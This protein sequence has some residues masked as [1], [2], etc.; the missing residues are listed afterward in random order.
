VKIH[1]K[2]ISVK[3]V[4][5]IVKGE[6]GGALAIVNTIDA[7]EKSQQRLRSQLLGKGHRSRYTFEDILTR[8]PELAEIK[9]LARMK[10]KSDA[11]VL[12]I[13]ETGTGKEL[14]AH[15]IH[16]SSRRKGW[17]LVTINCAALPESLLE[18]ELFGYEEGAFTGARK[19][20]KPGLFELAHKGTIFLDEI[21]EMNLNL[22]ARLL[23]V[24]ESREVMRIGGDSIIN[25][26]IRIIAA[27]NKEL[28]KLVQ[29]GTFRKD[30][31]Y[32]LNVLPIEI[33]PLRERTEDI[34]FILEQMLQKMGI[35][36]TF[37]EEAAE[38]LVA[39]P[40]HGNVRE[41]KNLAEYLAYLEKNVIESKDLLPL[42]KWP[43]LQKKS[44][45]EEICPFPEGATLDKEHVLFLLDC[46]NTSYQAKQRTGRR[47]LL[48][49]ARQ[50]DLFLTEAQIRKA[51]LRMGEYGFVRLSNGRG[52]TT[53]TPTGMEILKR[54]KAESFV[55][56][57]LQGVADRIKL[58]LPPRETE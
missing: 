18:S 51:L 38:M 12:I 57:P 16:S 19:G 11:S 1:S 52:G 33:P 32:R 26:D 6:T 55:G 3:V 39:Y 15:A 22:Q 8:N 42:L 47:S 17:Q 45:H 14:F 27:T 28:W 5:V 40:W 36:L 7:K 24:L 30:L 53:I 9:N 50:K 56:S 31:Y 43:N 58:S 49:C 54:M 20:G 4:P 29:E 37:V 46:L 44:D 10:A 34:L 48:E 35:R 21:G 13:G 23:R 41:L 25:V 2:N